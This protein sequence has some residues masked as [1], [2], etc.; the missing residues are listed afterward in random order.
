MRVER[1]GFVE[2]Y[3]EKEAAGRE[4]EDASPPSLPNDF[5]ARLLNLPVCKTTGQCNNCGRCE[6]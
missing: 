5:F 4:K 6:R 3:P 2:K 1:G